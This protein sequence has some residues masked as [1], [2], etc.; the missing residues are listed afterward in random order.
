MSARG[1]SIGDGRP[2]ARKLAGR[3]CGPLPGAR[4]RVADPP[5]QLR[6]DVVDRPDSHPMREQRI[7]GRRGFEALAG[8]DTREDEAEVDVV[9]G[10]LQHRELGAATEAEIALLRRDLD[11]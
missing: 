2:A 1:G 11:V 4:I 9:R 5:D 7:E 8:G 6:V 3:A 10:R